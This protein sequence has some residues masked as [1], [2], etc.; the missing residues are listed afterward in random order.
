MTDSPA[1]NG[2]P[3]N[4]AAVVTLYERVCCPPPQAIEH[5]PYALHSPTQSIGCG[6]HG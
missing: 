6:L 1:A 4:S 5:S 3:P 2:T